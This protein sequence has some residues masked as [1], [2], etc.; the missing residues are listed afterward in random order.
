MAKK[1]GKFFTKDEAFALTRKEQ[2]ALLNLR[3]V[4]VLSK[5]KERELVQM[6]MD[7]NP[8]SV[9]KIEPEIVEIPKPEEKKDD[10]VICERC[11]NVMVLLEDSPTEKRFFCEKCT[12]NI[13]FM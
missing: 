10:K 7:S 11:G 1:E 6:I 12:A 5:F 9:I 4:K 8:K 3:G 13:S 2:V